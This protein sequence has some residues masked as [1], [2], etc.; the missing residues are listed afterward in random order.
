MSFSIVRR[1][2]GRSTIEAAILFPVLFLVIIGM[3]YLCIL[4][5]QRAYIQALANDLAKKGKE[6]PSFNFQENQ[7]LDFDVI[8]KWED[9]ILNKTLTVI[10]EKKVEYPIFTFLKLFG[11]TNKM[12]LRATAVQFVENPVYFIRGTD[13]AVETFEEIDQRMGYGI[14]AFIDDLVSKLNSIFGE[15]SFGSI[16]HRNSKLWLNRA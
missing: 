3:I 6:T 16:G 12:V 2:H 1:V 10:V 4:L 14:K 8:T 15:K 11:F 7:A 13:F 5:F 9:Q